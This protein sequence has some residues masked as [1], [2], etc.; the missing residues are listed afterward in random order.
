[1]PKYINKYVNIGNFGE[2]GEIRLKLSLIWD[3]FGERWAK[4]HYITNIS[5]IGKI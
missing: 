2:F 4:T 1:M 3:F 5:H